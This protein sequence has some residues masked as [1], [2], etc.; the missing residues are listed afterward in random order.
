MPLVI[1]T[2]YYEVSFIH[3]QNVTLREAVCTMGM[4]YTGSSFAA[5]AAT[6]SGAWGTDIVAQIISNSYTH[7]RTTF[8]VAAGIIADIPESTV[9]GNGS[10]AASPNVAFLITK[11][12][13]VPGRKNRGRLYLPGVAEN[14]INAQGQVDATA[15]AFQTAQFATFYGDI[16]AVSFTPAI[17]HN[18]ATPSPT[19]VSQFVAQGVCATQRRR[20]RG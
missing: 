10:A 14:S 11:Q 19:L 17:L 1:P 16:G 5:D 12:T 6:V 9:G 13:G 18:S 20:L 8:R 15:Q 4:Q 3:R 7:V 2:G